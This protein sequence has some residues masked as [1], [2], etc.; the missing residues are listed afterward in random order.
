MRIQGRTLFKW[1]SPFLAIG[2]IVLR[3]VP[4]C[5]CSLI[6]CWSD[7]FP[8]MAGVGI[9]YI[10]GKRLASEMG[11]NVY[12]G[13][14]IELRAWEFLEVGANVS[15]HCGCYIDASG[16]LTIGSDVSIAHHSSIL[17][18]DHSWENAELPIRS[19]QIRFE[20]VDIDDDVWIGC[21]CRILAG[22]RIFRR[23]VVAAG[24]V[25]SRNVPPGVLVGGVP[26]RVIKSLVSGVEKENMEP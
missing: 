23:S 15:I 6:W 9:R 3:V 10:V 13:R 19:N 26:A 7:A 12:F 17:T 2:V 8:G 24:A 20:A 14:G 4:R 5:F 11:E 1:V 25:V 21:G 16:G 18:F 22:V